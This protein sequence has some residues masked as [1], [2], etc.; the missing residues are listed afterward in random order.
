M[1]KKKEN[2][3]KRKKSYTPNGAQNKIHS[4]AAYINSIGKI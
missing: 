3:K 4:R 1:K 2:S